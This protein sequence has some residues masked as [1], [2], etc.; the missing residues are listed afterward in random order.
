MAKTEKKLAWTTFSI[1]DKPENRPALAAYNELKKAQAQLKACREKFEPLA[2]AMLVKAGVAVEDEKAGDV[3]RL[4][5]NFGQLSFAQDKAGEGA[6][7]SAKVE[8]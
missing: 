6:A 3:I 5:Y 2:K 8:L 7:K 1:S 4:G